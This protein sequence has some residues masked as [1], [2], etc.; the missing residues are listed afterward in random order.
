MLAKNVSFG[1]TMSNADRDTNLS[2]WKATGVSPGVAN[3]VFTVQHSLGRVPITIVGQDTNNGG[4]IYR[5]GAW[6]TTSVVLKCTTATASF[7][8]ILG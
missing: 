7:N 6:T 5:G 8:V 1:S 4:V 2:I 3:T